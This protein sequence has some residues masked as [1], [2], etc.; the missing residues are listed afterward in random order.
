MKKF[1]EILLG[2]IILIPPVTLGQQIKPA[3]RTLNLNGV[4]VVANFSYDSA[5]C[6]DNLTCDPIFHYTFPIT[7]DQP[8]YDAGS[9]DLVFMDDFSNSYLDTI[10][11]WK[12]LNTYSTHN[13]DIYQAVKKIN[14]GIR[15]DHT[16]S[17]ESLPEDFGF[18]GNS[19]LLKARQLSPE[20]SL[21]CDDGPTS[22][23]LLDNMPCQG[24]P[25]TSCLLRENFDHCLLL[26]GFPNRR[27]FKYSSGII[28]SQQL[29]KHGY[30]EMRCKIDDVE[31]VKP[32]FWLY[33]G[34][35]EIDVFEISRR[36]NKNNEPVSVDSTGKEIYLTYHDWG[37]LFPPEYT[38]GSDA[39]EGTF[40][41]LSSKITNDWHTWGLL[42]DNYKLQW[43]LDGNKIYKI[44]RYFAFSNGSNFPIPNSESLIEFLAIGAE[45]KENMLFPKDQA[46]MIIQQRVMNYE[47]KENLNYFSELSSKG[48]FPQTMEIDYVKVWQSRNCSDEIYKCDG[49][50]LPGYVYGNSITLGSNDP[51]WPACSEK[52]R[53]RSYFN[54]NEPQTFWCLK[55]PPTD[56]CHC[57]P[58][59]DEVQNVHL[60]ATNEINLLPGFEV[61]W[62]ANFSAII[63][64][65]GT[66]DRSL[67]SAV[68][69]HILRESEERKKYSDSL[70]SISKNLDPK[71]TNQ[72]TGIPSVISSNKKKPGGILITPNPNQGKFSITKYNTD[73][74][75]VIISNLLGERII[76]HPVLERR[77][78]FDMSFLPKGL[79]LLNYV[80]PKGSTIK[81]IIVQ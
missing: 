48:N 67:E 14:E 1:I 60:T 76:E 34:S 69:E 52:V 62:G 36:L 73:P 13:Q 6:G 27:N 28:H 24:N 47:F 68:P 42:W 61:E 39:S 5:R 66:A 23:I 63:E 8:Y 59:P 12:P 51:S 31:G 58:R 26:D 15:R 3:T 30:F 49:W 7:L 37:K 2:A 79:Y 65:C 29:F 53:N 17:Y 20:L 40:M 56:A 9:L 32:A 22:Q 46:R 25:S 78:D 33:G 72:H 21:V 16:I 55:S 71:L 75:K 74:G 11:A 81:Q 4:S 64:N 50:E 35:T 18:T 44:F 38:S 57:K 77:M 41:T 54:M 19:L 80:D 43:F 45:I 10:N 70:L